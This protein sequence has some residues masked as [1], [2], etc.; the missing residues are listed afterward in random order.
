[1]LHIYFN[2]FI[3]MFCCCCLFLYCYQEKQ[4][5]FYFHV[6]IHFIQLQNHK[7]LRNKQSPPASQQAF[8]DYT[9]V[10]AW[11]DVVLVTINPY[12][13]CKYLFIYAYAVHIVIQFISLFNK[14]WS[15]VFV[16]SCQFLLFESVLWS[17][18]WWWFSWF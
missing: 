10:S 1:M 18:C 15:R 9:A 14:K 6:Y 3:I 16:T 11:G 17:E 4:S 7:F 5:K 8:Y 13:H 12:N 2:F